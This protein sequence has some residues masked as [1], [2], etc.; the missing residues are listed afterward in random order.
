[1]K[2]F[3]KYAALV[4][5]ALSISSHLN[6]QVNFGLKAGMNY[7]TMYDEET[8]V[9]FNAKPK[10][11]FAGG[12]FLSI[13]IIPFIGIQPEA[14][15]SQKGY[16]ARGDN[17]EYSLTTNHLDLPILLKLKPLPFLHIVGGPMYSYTLSRDEKITSG[18]RSVIQHEDFDNSNLRKNTLAAIGGL[19]LNFS[20]IVVSGRAGW[21][22]TNNNGDGS[23]TEPRYKNFFTQATLGFRF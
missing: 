3:F 10:A 23:S 16:I 22:L 6:A 20:R 13:P 9:G 11:G 5:F 8:P 15:F 7:S 14:M 17:Y 19:D 2:T 4:I 12:A 18:G 1:M 21:D